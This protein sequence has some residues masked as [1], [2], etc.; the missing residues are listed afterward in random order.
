MSVIY[1]S[2][3]EA[4][5]KMRLLNFGSGGVSRFRVLGVETG[6]ALDPTDTTAFV[7]GLSFVGD[8]NFTGTQ[9][10]IVAN[11]VPEP[12]SA[13]IWAVGVLGLLG[14]RRTSRME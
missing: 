2:Q 7:T 12:S 1:T 11:A 8:G 10:P 13:L 4:Q 9:T 14:L 6:A 3:L 5:E